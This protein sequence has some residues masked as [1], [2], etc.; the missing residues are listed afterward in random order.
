[1]TEVAFST[2]TSVYGQPIHLTATVNEVLPSVVTPLGNV[3]FYFNGDAIGSPVALIDGVAESEN[4]HTLVPAE[5][6]LADHIVVGEYTFS[7]E[8]SR[9]FKQYREG[10][11][12]D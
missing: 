1:M 9:K 7:A 8:T 4:L 10:D 2:A 6:L 5:Y 12:S 3:M 11:S